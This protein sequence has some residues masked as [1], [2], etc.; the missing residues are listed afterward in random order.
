MM[1]KVLHCD[2]EDCRAFM[3]VLARLE[4]VFGAVEV[5]EDGCASDRAANDR[6][7]ISA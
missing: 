2:C 3:E 5:V 1:V 6:E 7:L 4:R